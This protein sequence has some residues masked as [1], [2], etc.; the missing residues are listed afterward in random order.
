MNPRLPLPPLALVLALA[1]AAC[2]GGDGTASGEAG[3]IESVIVEAVTSTDPAKCTELMTRN[4]VEQ[5]ASAKGEA[6]VEECEEEAGDEAGE[7][8]SVDVTEIEVD[9]DKATARAAF[10]GGGLDGQTV[11]VAL[12]RGG[13]QWRLDQIQ[14]FAKLD[15]EALIAALRGQ[16]EATGKLTDEQTACVVD[17]LK[18]SSDKAFEGLLLNGESEELAEIAAGCE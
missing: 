16:L 18:E 10:G 17:G 8:E 5:T 1:L 14:G 6:A 11:I 13:D 2:G 7:A 15:R 12:V 9:G 3:Q 4:F